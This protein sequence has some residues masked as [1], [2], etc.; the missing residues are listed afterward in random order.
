MKKNLWGIARPLILVLAVALVLPAS[1]P[2]KAQEEGQT[3][4]L[5]MSPV[6]IEGEVK[7]S[8]S[9]WIPPGYELTETNPREDSSGKERVTWTDYHYRGTRVLDT[10]TA[11][12]G[13]LHRTFAYNGVGYGGGVLSV[14]ETVDIQADAEQHTRPHV[15]GTIYEEGPITVPGDGAS[16]QGYYYLST[17]TEEHTY[18]V[19]PAGEKIPCQWTSVGHYLHVRVALTEIRPLYTVALWAQTWGVADRTDEDGW[20]HTYTI[21]GKPQL[22]RHKE[23]IKDILASIRISSWKAPSPV[24][25]PTAIETEV[26]GSDWLDAIPLPTEISTEPEVVGTN[27]GLALLFALTFGL[28]SALFN[29]TLERN[30]ELIHTRL[31]PLLVPL[32]RAAERLPRPAEGPRIRIAKPII[33]LLFSALL[34]AFLDPEFGISASGAIVLLS[35]FVALAVL[36]YSYDGT[37]ALLGAKFYNLRARFQLFPLALAFGVACVLLTRWMDFHPGYL[38]GFVAGLTL[39][40]MEA[41]TPHRWALLVLAGVGAL[42]AASLAA[43]GLAVPVGRLAEGGLPG[44]SILYGVLVAIFVTGLEGLL[45]TL[46]PLTFMDGSKVMAWSRAVWGVAFGL[47]AWLF[48]HVLINPGSAYLEAFTSKKVLLMLGT[49]AAYGS[50]TVG[51]W[52]FFQWYARRRAPANPSG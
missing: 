4:T 2:V 22:A 9:L 23:Y 52:L 17:H 38:Y 42:L 46:V 29:A 26:T 41:E 1:S 51:T 15:E 34:Y 21:D 11:P 25:A 37:Q 30:E 16:Y 8:I 14:R 44:A 3:V 36:V 39:L 20:K 50:L 27:L 10:Q 6:G 43:W 19:S 35:L 49:L 31:A 40:G 33:L 32:R 24:A 5:E 47:A 18:V 12:D 13:S 28:T 7:G 45:F 48:F